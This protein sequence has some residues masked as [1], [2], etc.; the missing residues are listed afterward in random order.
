MNDPRGVRNQRWGRH[1]ADL[2]HSSLR[3]YD[4][5]TTGVFPRF[6]PLGPAIGPRTIKHGSAAQAY[7]R[8]SDRE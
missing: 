4:L 7:P 5:F 1:D 2:R 8:G 3:R 6:R